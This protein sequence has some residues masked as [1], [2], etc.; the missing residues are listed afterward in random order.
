MVLFDA[1]KV[2]LNTDITLLC[3]TIIMLCSQETLTGCNF[4]HSYTV[5]L[6]GGV[7]LHDKRSKVGLCHIFERL[8]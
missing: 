2:L 3:W 6:V 4:L 8:L 5:D 1:C 7:K